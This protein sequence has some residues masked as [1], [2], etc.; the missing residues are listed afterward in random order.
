MGGRGKPISVSLRSAAFWRKL[1]TGQTVVRLFK[2]TTYR[3]W[4]REGLVLRALAALAVDSSSI[5][6]THMVAHKHL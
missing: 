3:G 4:R 5:G 1:Q 2:K 6:S